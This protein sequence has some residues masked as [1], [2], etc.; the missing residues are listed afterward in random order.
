LVL[1][2][3]LICLFIVSPAMLAHNGGMA[4]CTRV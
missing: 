4:A 3:L 2:F 1:P